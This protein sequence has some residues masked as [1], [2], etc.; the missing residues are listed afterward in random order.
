MRLVKRL[1]QIALVLATAMA[2]FAGVAH[3]AQVIVVMDASGSASGQI[4]GVA[5]IDIARAALRSILP[6]A[7]DNLEIGL[8]AYGNRQREACDDYQLI[9]PLGTAEAFTSAAARVSPLGRSPIADA[10]VAAADALTEPEGATIIV[11]TDNADNCAPDP[12]ATIS[13]LHERMPDVTV[14]VVGLGIPE[15]EVDAIACFADITGGLYLRAENVAGFQ[16]ILFQALETAWGGPP[17]PMPTATIEFPGTIVQDR[18]FTVAYDGPLAPGDQIRIAWLG[19]PPDE[20]ITTVFTRADGAPV[21]IVAPDELGAYELRYWHAERNTVIARVPFRVAA[22]TPTLEAPAA[23]QQGAD[24]VV[25]WHADPA[26]GR[27]IQVAQ[28]FAPLAAAIATV[29]VIRGEP[30]VTLTA[31][32][33]PGTYELRLIDAPVG[34]DQPPE[35]RDNDQSRVLAR[36]TIVV[37]AAD[38]SL[39]VE[40]PITAG[41][42]F[43]TAWTGPGGRGDEIRLA[44]PQQQTTDYLASTAA[45]GEA[46]TF[47]A[48]YPPGTYE[49]RYWSAA[50]QDVIAVEE[51]EIVA[52]TASLSAPATLAGGTT[53]TVDWTGANAVGDHIALLDAG[54]REVL[55]A[56]LSLFGDPVVFEAPTTA[57]LYRL[58]YLA[59]NGNAVLAEQAVAVTAASASVST[60]RSA[61]VGTE[62]SVSWD[63]P[64]GRFDEIRIVGPD[65]SATVVAAIR[66]VPGT[67]ARLTA[68]AEPGRYRV[69]YWAG[70][71]VILASAFI[72]ITCRQCDSA[73]AAPGDALRLGP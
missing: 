21:E 62:I 61:E 12:C 3:A 34:K 20:Y 45:R 73:P 22:L 36:I 31:P 50:L 25:A 18:P 16:A 32:T 60:P 39:A 42:P 72:D 69:Q 8:V 7:P 40:G 65:E 37:E 71:D 47:T 68:P 43:R 53:F 54:G 29:P 38:V 58:V 19:T 5:K 57:G 6:E 48:P 13:D 23:V 9:A 28:P 35:L 51:V 59:D 17:P 41:L 4:G 33:R 55:S 66:V 56:R 70:A 14:S 15:D 24:I 1:G 46:V 52:A 27:T 64:A 30:T 10:T 49:V 63:G 26:G 11:I 67:P 2:A 44:R